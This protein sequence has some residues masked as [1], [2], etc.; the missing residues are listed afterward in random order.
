MVSVFGQ[1]ILTISNANRISIFQTDKLL[2]GDYRLEVV[3][4]E[5]FDN[6]NDQVEIFKDTENQEMYVFKTD[7]VLRFLNMEKFIERNEIASGQLLSSATKEPLIE[8]IDLG[9]M[10]LEVMDSQDFRL[11]SI[12]KYFKIGIF[13]LG[14]KSGVIKFYDEK[15]R[16]FLFELKVFC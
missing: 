7:T 12:V 5:L 1:F 10:K 2:T 8:E 4:S 14:L 16:H 13:G 15:T 11:L 9:I 3:V 6:C